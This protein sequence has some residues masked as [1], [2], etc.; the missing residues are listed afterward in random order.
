MSEKLDCLIKQVG[1]NIHKLIAWTGF[2]TPCIFVMT[3]WLKVHPESQNFANPP[4]SRG[5][6]EIKVPQ[7]NLF[8]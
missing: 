8:L 6:S 1:I 5:S 7:K 3:R 4:Y 2:S